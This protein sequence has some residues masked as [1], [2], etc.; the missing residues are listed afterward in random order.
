MNIS[1]EKTQMR[2]KQVKDLY[3]K[4]TNTGYS[5]ITEIL[6]I[7]TDVDKMITQ[8]QNVTA[9]LILRTHLAIMSS[10]EQKARACANHVW[11]IGGTIDTDFEKMYL[12]DLMSLGLID[13]AGILLKRRLENIEDNIKNFA[14]E[15]LK[16]A[17]I[18]GNS[19]LIKKITQY[20]YGR[21]ISVALSSFADVYQQ[22]NYDDHFKQIQAITLNLFGKEMCGYDFNVYNDRGFTDLEIIIYFSN[23]NTEIYKFLPL[24]ESKISGYFLTSGAKRINNLSFAIKHIKNYPTI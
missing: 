19:K 3:N 5:N 4:V 7:N 17:I 10:Q 12:N 8:Y 14:L 18:T 1:P 16:F 9:L 20:D 21:T 23:Y 22:N 11:E 24:L 6:R 15:M 2:N 13:M